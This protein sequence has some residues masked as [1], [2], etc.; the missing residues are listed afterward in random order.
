[1]KITISGDIGS[2]KSTVAKLLCKDLKLEYYSTGRM[3]RRIALD[4]NLS[5]RELTELSE[6]DERI[7]KR[8]DHYQKKLGEMQDDFVLEG[9]LGW[10]FVQDSVKVYLKV[11]PREGARRILEHKRKNEKYKSLEQAVK[12]LKN[13]RESENKRYKR[14]YNAD[15]EDMKNYD[16]IID[17]TNISAAKVTN[18]IKKYI[19]KATF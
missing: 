14:L 1:M 15:V 2:G 13:R 9:R 18:K 8:I 6:K 16:L 5:L 4:M 7:D 19:K 12:Q 3:F 11:E 17:T 10:Y